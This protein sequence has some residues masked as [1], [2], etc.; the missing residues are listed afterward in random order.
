MDSKKLFLKSEGDKY[1]QR[2]KSAL[3]NNIAFDTKFYASF[4]SKVADKNMNIVEI[5]AGNGRM[6]FQMVIEC[7]LVVKMF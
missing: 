4:L 5:G 6:Q 7:F 1:Y 2:N 3:I